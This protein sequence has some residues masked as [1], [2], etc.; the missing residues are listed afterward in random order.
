[1]RYCG[2]E[3]AVSVRSVFAPQPHIQTKPDFPKPSL[4][5]DT[6][7]SLNLSTACSESPFPATLATAESI[8]RRAWVFL[9]IRSHAWSTPD[10]LQTAHKSESSF[11]SMCSRYAHS[12][13]AGPG[14]QVYC[15]ASYSAFPPSQDSSGSRDLPATIREA[16]SRAP[17]LRSGL[18]AAFT[19][20]A[21]IVGYNKS[22][23][24]PETVSVI[25]LKQDCP[26]AGHA[27]PESP[28]PDCTYSFRVTTRNPGV[29]GLQGVP[30]SV[31]DNSN[32]RRSLKPGIPQWKP[33]QPY[34]PQATFLVRGL[35]MTR[36]L[37]PPLCHSPGH[38]R[39]IPV[40]GEVPNAA[41][42]G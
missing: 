17:R 22:I 36:R 5:T 33:Q 4:Q 37:P 9:A 27:Q 13:V 16:Q 30:A 3:S 25:H 24:G 21:C 34:K 12:S 35:V 7:C 38:M 23:Q 11:L 18:P 39:S 31:P 15:P 20:A 8:N 2:R 41:E 6:N 14:G 32:L 29:P 40:S 1:M 28:L 42:S 26:G 19:R 10:Q